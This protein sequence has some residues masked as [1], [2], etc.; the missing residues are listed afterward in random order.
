MPK[1]YTKDKK[2]GRAKR[3]AD[4]HDSL[5]GPG[6]PVR[7]KTK[8][9][10][11][12]SPFSAGPRPEAPEHRSE[13]MRRA[14]NVSDLFQDHGEIIKALAARGNDAMIQAFLKLRDHLKY[15]QTTTPGLD[16]EQARVEGL[17]KE[18]YRRII[19]AWVDESNNLE[20][21]FAAW[22]IQ[23]QFS[24][25]RLDSLI[26]EVVSRVLNLLDTIATRT[27]G[28]R[29][30]RS[31]LRQSSKS[32]Y[33][34]LSN[35][36]SGVCYQTLRLLNTLATLGEGVLLAELK[37]Q[38]QWDLKSLPIIGA[39]RSK[40]SYINGRVLWM[41]FVLAFFCHGDAKLKSAM[42]DIKDIVP[43][44]FKALAS[45]PYEVVNEL[46]TTIYDKLIVDDS[47]RRVAK[48]ALLSPHLVS[49]LV[50]ALGKMERAGPDTLAK[51]KGIP[52]FEA[53]GVVRRPVQA[54]PVEGGEAGAEEAVATA[55]D[56]IADLA[57]RFIM[58]ICTVPGVGLCY[59]DYG[60]YSAPKAWT[61]VE[62]AAMVQGGPDATEA[63]QSGRAASQGQFLCNHALLRVLTHSF[64][65]TSDERQM[66][67]V[68]AILEAAP[69]LITP[70]WRNFS[71]S[72]EPRLSLPY[73]SNTVLALK[74]LKL[75][76]S[77]PGT[78]S[79]VTLNPPSVATLVEHI[80]PTPL[81]RTIMTRGIQHSRQLVRYRSL[82]MLSVVMR[83]LGQAVTWLDA[84][85][86]QQ[87]A[88]SQANMASWVKC[89]SSLLNTVKRRLPEW[90]VLIAAY[91]TCA[92]EKPAGDKGNGKVPQLRECPL[93]SRDSSQGLD[94]QHSLVR[95]AV[96]QAMQGYQTHFSDTV[97]EFKFDVGKLLSEV[98]SL[99]RDAD[100][101]EWSKSG[102]ARKLDTLCLHHALQL[103]EAS[104]PAY[105]KWQSKVTLTSG[106]GSPVQHSQFGVILLL[107]LTSRSH[108]VQAVARNIALNAMTSFGLFDQD[109]P[110]HRLASEPEVWLTS[111]KFVCDDRS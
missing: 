70:F 38:F 66:R 68:V 13:P 72:F 74:V 34:A 87:A 78:D 56:S 48:V 97:T 3:R 31:V 25:A 109:A 67:I 50:K 101:P 44:L 7:K 95:T 77:V 37:D 85:I 36:R 89:K 24:I 32:I 61:S 16:M 59:S 19:Y 11:P 5:D 91:R 29:I 55:T 105:V 103:L 60:I 98:Y 1:P 64:K 42:L 69:E 88:D 86:K 14:T 65:P 73:L 90:P 83:K 110:Q 26:P 49:E 104:P 102:M 107:Y 75:P 22:D 10:M 52:S 100:A 106:V 28:V 108:D 51:V 80:I 111:L 58:A 23:H 63:R 12:R 57:E 2:G 33:R 4:R 92:G 62:I 9:D 46:L 93:S 71:N 18:H 40:S 6:S 54:T 35:P 17:E 21:V 27:Q 99:K 8:A 79:P 41:R 81:S 53:E 76:V 84:R 43:N 30:A 45:D 94:E 15:C 20:R 96:L 39:D 47:V 82:Q